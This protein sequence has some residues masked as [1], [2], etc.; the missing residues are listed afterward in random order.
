M[1]YTQNSW[2]VVIVVEVADVGYKMVY[3]LMF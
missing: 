3:L 2:S 1:D